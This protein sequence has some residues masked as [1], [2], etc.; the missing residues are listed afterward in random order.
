[1]IKILCNSNQIFVIAD[2]D[3]K[4]GSIVLIEK[5]IYIANDI[6]E[7]LYLML[8]NSS[9]NDLIN[10]YPRSDIKLINNNSPYNIDLYKLINKCDK[11]LRKFL[12]SIN[13]KQLYHFYYKILF[14][15]FQINN[16]NTV[17][18]KVCILKTGAMMNHSCKPNIIFYENNNSMIFEANCDIKKGTELCYSYL[19]NC[20]LVQDKH[21]YLIDHYNFICEC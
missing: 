14:N 18:N 17:I 3:I 5:P 1:M 11:N 12:L 9:D 8:K 19:R 4:K 16:V 2:K 13:E 21:K 7:L 6:I 10:L 20:D 15:A